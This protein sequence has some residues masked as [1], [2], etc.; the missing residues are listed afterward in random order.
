MI[1]PDLAKFLPLCLGLFFV[2]IGGLILWIAW[3][4]WAGTQYLVV[5][6]GVTPDT[7]YADWR[8]S[9]LLQRISRFWLFSIMF[10][11]GLLIGGCLVLVIGR[12]LIK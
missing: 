9:K 6:D 7:H 10:A 11:V 3:R 8:E 12:Q 2:A 4:V 1:S 5:P